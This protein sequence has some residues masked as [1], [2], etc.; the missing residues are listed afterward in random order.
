MTSGQT[1]RKL[2]M[3]DT[4]YLPKTKVHEYNHLKIK[5]SSLAK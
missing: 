1:E 3:Y 4:F 2:F 5:Y